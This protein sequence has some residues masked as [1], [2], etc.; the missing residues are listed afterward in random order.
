M[1]STGI[2][3]VHGGLHTGACWA[4]TVRS[5]GELSPGTPVLAVDL[6]GRGGVPG[7]LSTMTIAEQARSAVEQIRARGLVDVVLVGHSLAGITVPT[8]TELLGARTV[9]HL[10]FVS[11]LVPAQGRTALGALGPPLSIITRIVAARRPTIDPFPAWVARAVFG[12]GMTTSQRRTMLQASCRE[13]LL[14]AGEP[15]DR[16]GMPRVPM[17]WVLTTKDRT[18][19]ARRQRRFMAHLDGPV[20]VVPIEA[21]HDVMITE[22]EQLARILLGLAR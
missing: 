1:T 16:S 13:S 9:R 4:P 6:P 22:P 15:V 12:N 21:C 3:L 17:T 7:D 19:S 5:L 8:V 14:P 10:V 18:L 11:S 2:V 20:D